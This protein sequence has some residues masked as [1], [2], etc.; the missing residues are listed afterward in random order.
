MTCVLEKPATKPETEEDPQRKRR[1]SCVICGKPSGGTTSY[2]YQADGTKVSGV[3]FCPFHLSNLE[4]YAIPVF[5]N[6]VA[7]ERFKKEHPT[8]Y[9]LN[10]A[11]KKIIFLKT[12]ENSELT[13]E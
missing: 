4:N 5:E 7:L 13:P 8:L 3:P 10:V 1:R 2:L 11:G 12:E 9:R 6:K